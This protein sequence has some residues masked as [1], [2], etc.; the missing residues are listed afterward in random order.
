MSQLPIG[1]S[2]STLGEV[3]D[4]LNGRGFK[5]SEWRK[6]GRPIIRIQNLTGT[7]EQFNYFDGKP[8]PQYTA[9]RGDLLMSWAATLGVFVWNGPEAVVNQHIFKVR[10]HIDPG[11]HRYLL[12]SVLHDLMR[13]TH[14]SGMIHITKDRFETTPVSIPPLA[15]Q[16]RIVAAIEEQFSRLDVGAAALERSR[17]HVNRLRAALVHAFLSGEMTG[18]WRVEHQGEGVAAA[19]ARHE[20]TRAALGDAD[21][22][23]PLPDTWQWVPWEAILSPE[24][25]AFRRGPFGSALTKATFVG[26]GYK[27]YEQYCP[28]NDDCSFGR[29]YITAERYAELESFS[30]R[31]GDFLISCS[32]SLG[33]ITQVPAKYEEGVINQAL[34]R[35]RV[36]PT[37]IDA[38]Y[39]LHLVRSPYFQSQILA[40]STGSAMVNVKGVRELKAIPVPLPPLDEQRQI[41]SDLHAAFDRCDHVEIEIGRAM[42]RADRLRSTILKAAF[43]GELVAQNPSDGPASVLLEQIAAGRES[44]P[45]VPR[46]RRK[47]AS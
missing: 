45:T 40:N 4:Y 37:L 30:V 32:G 34:L 44:E 12:L 10:S 5:K 15:E 2:E 41:V 47:V 36:D 22:L 6:T 8:E 43:S 13:Q 1:W 38:T 35:V 31:A 27:V 25:G 9:Q 42:F 16:R 19:L 24:K 23:A 17:R 21:G 29:Y 11:F 3:G 18:A 7:S 26:A 39:F 33:R 20:P 14:G 46:R 28:I